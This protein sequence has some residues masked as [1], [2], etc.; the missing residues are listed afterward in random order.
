MSVNTR[1]LAKIQ[2]P[3][4]KKEKKKEIY[5]IKK[6]GHRRTNLEKQDQE[7]VEKKSDRDWMS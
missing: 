5:I 4:N 3:K 7:T 6:E 2:G 1:W